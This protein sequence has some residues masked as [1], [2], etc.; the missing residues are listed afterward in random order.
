MTNTLAYYYPKLIMTIKGL[1][2]LT[3]GA[4]LQPQLIPIVISYSVFR[5]LSLPPYSNV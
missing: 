2:A 1:M 4:F 3:A 5:C